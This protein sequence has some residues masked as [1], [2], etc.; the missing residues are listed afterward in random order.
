MEFPFCSD[1]CAYSLRQASSSSKHFT[2]SK[3]I[4]Y[5]DRFGMM[6]ISFMVV[7]S[8]SDAAGF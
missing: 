2:R 5:F 3:K 7:L 1:Y 8:C 6:G 4:A